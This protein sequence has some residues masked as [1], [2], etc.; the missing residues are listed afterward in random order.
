MDLVTIIMAVILSATSPRA[1]SH[2]CLAPEH[3]SSGMSL[4]MCIKLA[5]PTFLYYYNYSVRRKY[6]QESDIVWLLKYY[7]I[8]FSAKWTF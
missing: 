1:M 7:K 8:F 5:E 4:F 6:N 3:E 2:I